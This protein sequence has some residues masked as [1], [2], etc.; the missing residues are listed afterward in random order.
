ME[1]KLPKDAKCSLF[2]AQTVA[3][4][5]LKQLS[6]DCP[7]VLDLIEI[8]KILRNTRSLITK[9]ELESKYKVKFK[10]LVKF[11][12]EFYQYLVINESTK[13][14]YKTLKYFRPDIIKKLDKL[15]DKYRLLNVEL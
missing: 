15:C 2:V 6:V 13:W 8:K 4:V 14:T 10:V 1:Y 11:Y 12:K 9:E 3:N 7:L 5:T